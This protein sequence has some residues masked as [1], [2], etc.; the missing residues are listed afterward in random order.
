MDETRW[1]LPNEVALT[2]LYTSPLGIQEDGYLTLLTQYPLVVGPIGDGRLGVD[3]SAYATTA[4][5]SANVTNTLLQTQLL[6]YQPAFTVS[7]PFGAQRLM[8]NNLLLALYG[9]TCVKL[10][11]DASMS[12]VAIGLDQTASYTVG[13]LTCTNSAAISGGL[14]LSSAANISGGLVVA[15]GGLV[16]SASGATII[17]PSSITASPTAFY[18]STTGVNLTGGGDCYGRCF[19]RDSERNQWRVH[20]RRLDRYKPRGSDNW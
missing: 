14:T 17:G 10:Y 18:V 9:G 11:M 7:G 3:L 16:V 15:T 2:L 12:L 20:H 13:A 1:G 4:S 19:R 8:I 6:S 5:L